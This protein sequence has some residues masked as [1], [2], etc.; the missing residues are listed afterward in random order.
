MPDSVGLAEKKPRRLGILLY[1]GD[2]LTS[3]PDGKRSRH[4]R[5]VTTDNERIHILRACWRWSAGCALKTEFAYTAKRVP[6]PAEGSAICVRGIIK[7]RES[8]KLSVCISTGNAT[9]LEA[10]HSSL[11]LTCQKPGLRKILQMKG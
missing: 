8:S 11:A 4:S 3:S 1:E 2:E 9:F 6:W 7:A 10:N 5:M